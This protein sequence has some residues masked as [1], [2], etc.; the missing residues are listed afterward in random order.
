M[1]AKRFFWASLVLC[2]AS[3]PAS[4]H[5][6]FVRITPP[7]EADAMHRAIERSVLVTLPDA[8]LQWSVRELLP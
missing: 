5:F 6:L 7:A 1:T 3:Q 8:G 2:L 4:A